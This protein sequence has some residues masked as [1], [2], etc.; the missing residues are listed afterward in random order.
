LPAALTS[1]LALCV[2]ASSKRAR[3]IECSRGPDKKRRLYGELIAATQASRELQALAAELAKIAGTAAKR[4]RAQVDHYLPLIARIIAQSERRV[5]NG[6]AVPAGE[7][8]VSLFERTLTSSFEAV[9]R[10]NTANK[11]LPPWCFGSFQPNLSVRRRARRSRLRP[12]GVEHPHELC[13][14]LLVPSRQNR[15]RTVRIEPEISRGTCC[16]QPGY[17]D[18]KAFRR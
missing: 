7:K 9:V 2:T 11:Q 5:L 17:I 10:C 1:R 3:A 14:N 12:V 4:W 8:L 18:R 13:V 6:A 15:K 16:H